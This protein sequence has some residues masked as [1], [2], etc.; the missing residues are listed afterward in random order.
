VAWS[1]SALCSEELA[2]KPFDICVEETTMV[3]EVEVVVVIAEVNANIE[4]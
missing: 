3:V 2:P 1:T 4:G